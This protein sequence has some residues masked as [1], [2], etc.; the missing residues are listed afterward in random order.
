MSNTGT[1]Q[2]TSYFRTLI[3]TVI[4][5][6]LSIALFTALFIEGGK[7]FIPF[8]ITVEIGIF[9]IIGYCIYLI[10][11]REKFL[12]SQKDPKNYSFKFDICPDYYIKRYDEQNKKNFCSNEY[13]I[14]DKKRPSTTQYTMKIVEE[15]VSLPSTHSS[16]F[17]TVD[18]TTKLASPPQTWDKFYTDTLYDKSFKNDQA[19]CDA[20]N[21]S[22]TSPVDSKVAGL[23]KVPWTYLRTRCDGLYGRT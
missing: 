3:F 12:D 13:T 22:V 19:R 1:I 8:V 9:A 21:P 23:K 7:R 17:M 6:M 10:V 18:P 16:T 11:Q 2:K 15:G 20:I 5:A 4:A 14:V